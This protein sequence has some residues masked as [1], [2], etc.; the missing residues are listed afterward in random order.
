MTASDET[1]DP[2]GESLLA[3]LAGAFATRARIQQA[4]GVIMATTHRAADAAYL[5][6]RTRAAETGATLTDTATAV[7]TDRQ[8]QLSD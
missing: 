2:G 5:V 3:G 1:L 7:I 8:T 4:L 6:L